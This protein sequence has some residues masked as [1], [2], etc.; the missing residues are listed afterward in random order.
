[1][2]TDE[3]LTISPIHHVLGTVILPGS[4]SLSNRV[5]LLS[6]L[7]EGM[8]K[9][10]N[11]LDSDD[12][13]YMVGALKE[14]KISFQEDRGAKTVSITGCKGKIP[15]NGTELFLGNAGTAIRPLT[16]AVTLGNGRFV[17]DG[18]E[19]M[20]QRPIIDL[21]NGLEQLGVEIRCLYGTTCPPVE[22]VA[23]GLPGGTTQLSGAI[24][25]Q[26]LSSILMAAPYAK[27]DVQIL[28]KDRL[29]SLPYVQ[30]TI[31]L[32][33][34]FG[35]VVE[36]KDNK[37]FRIRSGQI[38]QSPGEFFVEGDAS[39]ASYFLAAAAITGGTVTIKGCG[40]ESVQGDVKFANVLE[41]MGAEVQ[42]QPHS[43]TLHGN[44]TLRGVDVDM[45]MMPD[46]AMT[47]AVTALFASGKTVIRNIYNWRLKETERMH[48]V[49]TELRKLGA[50]V[51]VG[52]DY[53]II[54]PPQKIES[55]AI[56]TY[57]DHRMAMS[58][59]LAACGNVPVII[60]DPKC[61]SKTFPE[62][63]D[64]LFDLVK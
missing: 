18:V 49:S 30:M 59:S 6:M 4:K 46:A 51:E 29:V 52:Y 56:D 53:L 42:W 39:S 44:K 16:A 14:L 23:A 47:L 7:A 48:A 24:S 54:K 55:V 35:V 31:D 38:Y 22:V 19:R 8:T 15:V 10:H 43:L 1:M 64:I 25:S 27:K 60:N 32:M 37:A 45:N 9:I 12:V 62:Y 17:L 20:R 63:F 5:L 50:E 33:Q 13:R 28:I 40:S 11:L 21:V 36:N 2:N 41:Q 34:R 61:V 57:E 26:Y 58:F 3:Q